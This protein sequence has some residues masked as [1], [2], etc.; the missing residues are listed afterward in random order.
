MF[1]QCFEVGLVKRFDMEGW[2]EE[3]SDFRERRE[4]SRLE[5]ERETS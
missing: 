4:F 2:G 1:S 5:R 3:E